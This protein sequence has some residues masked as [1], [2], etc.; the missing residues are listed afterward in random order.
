MKI[1]YKIILY[2]G[3]CKFF[4]RGYACESGVLFVIST[5]DREEN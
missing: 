5:T 2:S 1:L 4:G 3:I